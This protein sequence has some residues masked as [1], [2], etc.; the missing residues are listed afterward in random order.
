MSHHHCVPLCQPPASSPL[1]HRSM[2]SLA[3]GGAA[4]GSSSSPAAAGKVPS[5]SAFRDYIGCTLNSLM[6]LFKDS[7]DR[8]HDIHEIEAS[9]ADT[10]AWSALTADER[11]QKEQFY[12]SQQHTTR[13]FLRMA[14]STLK[15]LNTLADDA[16][17][18][19]RGAGAARGRPHKA[20]NVP[21][22]LPLTSLSY[23]SM[24]SS[25]KRRLVDQ[26]TPASI[27]WSSWLG[28]GARS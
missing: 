6:Y 18:V 21:I 22:F 24:P 1:V 7:L 26:P 15:W 19:R 27:S 2:V 10:A 12:A 14:V 9:K 13:G 5:A 3:T 11:K 25:I 17:V 8:L 20:D 28:P 23:R 4:A 16:G